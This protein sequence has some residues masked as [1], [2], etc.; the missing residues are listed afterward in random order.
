MKYS[1]AN[2]GRIFILRLEHGDRIP[3]TIEEFAK[4][5]N[6]ESAMLHFL[7]GADKGSKVLV[8]HESGSNPQPSPMITSLLGTSEA[9]GF[10][11]L[12]INEEGAPKVHLHCAFGRNEDTVTGCTREGVIIWHVGEVVLFELV[13]T[14][15]KR[16]IDLHTGFEQ[17]ECE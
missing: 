13:N 7:G 11:T 8:G 3:D 14:S 9:I 6:V 4:T 10:G 1:E 15:V 2:L 5:H 17:L 12:F 16:K